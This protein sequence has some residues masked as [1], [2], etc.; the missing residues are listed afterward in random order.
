MKKVQLKELAYL[1]TGDKGDI[2]N[3]AVAAFNKENYEIIK[4]QLTA[5]KV[6]KHF[7]G[8]VKG[9]VYRYEL[10]NLNALNFVL[11][12]AIEGGGSLTLSLDIL[13]KGYGASFARMMIEVD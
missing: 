9:K 7:N 4:K 3:V 2:M 1:K 10:R 6:K 5:D 8:L 11:C 13:G 12:N